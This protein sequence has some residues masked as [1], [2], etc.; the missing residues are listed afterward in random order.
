MDTHLFRLLQQQVY[1]DHALQAR[2]FELTDRKDFFSAIQALAEELGHPL[3]E[4]AM[5]E[6]IRAGRRAWSDRNKQ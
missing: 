6:V 5:I 3:E 2:L 4:T 1:K